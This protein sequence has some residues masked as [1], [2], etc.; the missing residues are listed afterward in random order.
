VSHFA[1]LFGDATGGARLVGNTPGEGDA[2]EDSWA[3]GVTDTAGA[4]FSDDDNSAPATTRATTATPPATP[5]ATLLRCQP[6][7]RV[8]RAR[9]AR[10]ARQSSTGRN[11]VE[12]ARGQVTRWRRGQWASLAVHRFTNKCPKIGHD[13]QQ[14]GHLVQIGSQATGR[15]RGAT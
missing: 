15:V 4:R 8:R 2:A 1:A 9:P 5:A 3:G 11:P 14:R 7:G 13:G 10:D 6:T 12:D